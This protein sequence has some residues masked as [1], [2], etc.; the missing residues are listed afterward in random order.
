MRVMSSADAR[1]GVVA[2]RTILACMLLAWCPYAF[3]LNPALDVSQ[4]AHTAWRFREGF[5]NG[6]IAG[7]AQTPDGYLWLG[8][9]FGLLRFDGVRTVPWQPPA[10]QHLPANHIR[11]LLAARDG[12]LWIGTLKGLASWKGGKLTEYKELAGQYVDALI[13]DREGTVWASGSNNPGRLCAIQNGRVACYGG[14]GF[15]P[16]VESLYED[17][18][19]N[20][21]VGAATGL[22]RWKPGPPTH[23]P[24]SGPI[25]GPHALIGDDKSAL[26]ISASS[27]MRQ[28][29]EGKVERYPVRG[30]RRRFTWPRLFRDRDGVL[31]MGSTDGGL[32]HVHAGRTDTFT[33]FDGLSSD[34]V[35]NIF[36]DREGNVWVATSTGLDRFRDVSVVTHSAR[37]GLSHD[38][39]ESVVA[40][41]DGSVWLGTDDGLNR[42]SKG[43]FTIPS[44]GSSKRDGRFDGLYP[45]ALLQ[46]DRGRM[47]ISTRQGIGYLENGQFV[48]VS[49]ASLG[50]VRSIAEDTAGNL[51]VASQDAGLL[52]VS[53]AHDVRQMSWAT[54][55]HRDFAVTLAADGLKGGLW[56]GFYQGG[57]AHLA[58]GQ[59][60]ASYAAANG[61]GEGF[62]GHLRFDQDGVLWAATEGG[63][64]RVKAGRVA[65]L[66][67][68]SGLP[69]DTV[70][71]SMEDDAHSLWLYMACGLVRIA[72]PELDVWAATMDKAGVDKKADATQVIHPMVFDSSD[73]VTTVAS[74][75]GLS[76]LVA[77]SSDGR[78]W[79][80][81]RGG[82]SVIDPGHPTLNKLPPPVHVEQVTADRKTY[83]ATSDST[84]QLR[85]PALIRD[86]EIDYTALSLVAPEKNRFRVKLEGWDRDW[87]DVGTRRQAFYNNLP[88]RSYRF[89]VIASNNSGVWNETGATLDFS[90]APA[91]H[92]TAW[93]R[94]A[95]VI[96]VLALLWAA[97]QY[98]VRQ[99]AAA[100]D[101]RLQERVNERTRIARDLHDTLL[102]SF[103][104]LLF[105]FQAATNK[106]SDSPVKQEFETAIDQAAQAITEGRDAVQNLRTSTVVT[107]DLAEAIGTLG[108]ELAAAQTS[109]AKSRPTVVDVAVEG[110]SRDLHPIIR[111]D[112]YRI[113]GEALRNAFRHAHARHIEVRI[114]YD[115]AQLQVRVRD[116]GTGIDPAVRDQQKP[117]HF[118]L[119]GMR[120]RADLVGAHLTVWSEVGLGT[121]VEL[122]IPAAAA[123]ATPRGRARSWLFVKRADTSS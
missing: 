3:A 109:D 121:E 26:L 87:Q 42:W 105:R 35:Q 1:R 116:D 73:G 79:F 115:D 18:R 43:H 59:V 38:I 30:A 12:T 98:R 122:T 67:S 14:D 15:G 29:A 61:M 92:Q 47:W 77:K 62:V 114:R 16:S 82:L 83:D 118:G 106:L 65:T 20:L 86:L 123:Y 52:R 113:A 28:L 78:L 4:Y 66:T 71:W 6:K 60:R 34:D 95:S 117:G 91:Y 45:L 99:V 8:T 93:F 10:G 23:Y 75:N 32:L 111:D 9:E 69:C 103:H 74:A 19:G 11:E 94:A 85:L 55:G 101:A 70:H 50:I 80:V 96:G 25:T 68:K 110:T 27:G 104:G 53:P 5:S 51:W 48:S 54:L 40:D 33:Q 112:I 72:R 63:L 31:W 24:L 81:T 76:P 41:R 49:G 108:A 57:I 64:S 120:E 17:S 84:G 21:W 44:T 13:E 46:D 37:Q 36:E 102:Q 107:N 89:R 97:Y 7:I 56:L 90:I 58:D 22:W 2:R 100:F 119:P 88:P 39:V